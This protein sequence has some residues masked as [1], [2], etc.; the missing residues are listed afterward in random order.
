[1]GLFG[2]GKSND[3]KCQHWINK[4]TTLQKLGRDEEA[5]K[6]FAESEKLDES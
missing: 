6:C 3:E 2:F 5:D 4:G 1:M